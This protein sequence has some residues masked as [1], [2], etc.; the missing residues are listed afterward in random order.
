MELAKM[1]NRFMDGQMVLYLPIPP[2][3]RDMIIVF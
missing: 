1:Q 3:T 2:I